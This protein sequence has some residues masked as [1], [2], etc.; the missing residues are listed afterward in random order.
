MG[1]GSRES[2]KG[3]SPSW[4]CLSRTASATCPW[5]ANAAPTRKCPWGLPNWRPMPLA[6][7]SATLLGAGLAQKI[8]L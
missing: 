1:L 5:L 6:A 8:A 4:G 7:A 3:R 2:C